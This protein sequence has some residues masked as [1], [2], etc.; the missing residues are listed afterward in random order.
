V[1]SLPT[2]SESFLRPVG[3]C[4]RSV[5]QGP[6]RC[7]LPLAAFV[8]LP[9]AGAN[10]PERTARGGLRRGFRAA[11]G[12]QFPRGSSLDGLQVVSWAACSRRLEGVAVAGSG[13]DA[14]DVLPG[15]VL[16]EGISG[17]GP[18]NRRGY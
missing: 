14:S 8:L 5:Y 10:V 18:V 17:R 2:A 3:R 13:V 1:V 6:S 16:S 15:E 12:R 9:R 7:R 11:P 4:C